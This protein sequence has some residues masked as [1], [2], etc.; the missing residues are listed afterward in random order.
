MKNTKQENQN[1]IHGVYLIKK[2][3]I[4]S[5][6][7]FTL[8]TILYAII[9]CFVNL[10]D[11]AMATVKATQLLFFY[12]FSLSLS[13]ANIVLCNNKP[14]KPLRVVLH[15]IIVITAFILFI[16]IHI[17]DTVESKNIIVVTFVLTLLYAVVMTLYLV[18]MNIINSSK[19]EDKTYTS[20]YKKN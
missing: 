3:L 8:I 5:A 20:V 17:V 2:A 14:S 9:F 15:Y 13:F 18:I 12:P 11:D 4:N 6:V 1:S 19:K 7:I 10:K 16:Y